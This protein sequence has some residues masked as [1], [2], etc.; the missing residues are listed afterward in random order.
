MQKGKLSPKWNHQNHLHVFKTEEAQA[1]QCKACADRWSSDSPSNMEY[2]PKIVDKT[3]L[4]LFVG[5]EI[6]RKDTL[7]RTTD[8][9][10]EIS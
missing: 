7:M 5:E 2:V 10:Q 1:I 9:L 3:R 6:E 8:F 4:T